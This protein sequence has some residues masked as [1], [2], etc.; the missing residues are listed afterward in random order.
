[1][2]KSPLRCLWLWAATVP[3]LAPHGLRHLEGKTGGNFRAETDVDVVCWAGRHMGAGQDAGRVLSLHLPGARA[4][5][6]G[7]K[8]GVHL[9]APAGPSS[10]AN[11]RYLT[12]PNT[13]NND[14]HC[15]LRLR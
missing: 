3:W 12:N 15:R 1:M 7:A 14:T 5:L 6:R 10:G 13:N 11:L 9:N 8:Y 4:E 2:I